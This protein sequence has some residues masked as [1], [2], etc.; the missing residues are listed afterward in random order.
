[1]A[2][3]QLLSHERIKNILQHAII[4]NRMPGAYCFSGEEGIGKDALAI[5]FARTVNCSNPVIND[6]L[7]DSCGECKSCRLFNELQ[8]PNLMFITALPSGT[9][10]ESRSDSPLDKLTAAQLALIKEQLGIKAEN[11]Y[12]QINIP[13]ANLIK[14]SSI[15][16]IKRKLTLSASHFGRRVVIISKADTMT[17]EAANAFLKTLEEPHENITIILTTSKPET[18]LPTIVSRCQQVQCE[19]LS[20]AEIARFLIDKYNVEAEKAETAAHFARGSLSRAADMLDDGVQI[21]RDMVVDMLRAAMKKN[22]F[23]IGLLVYIDEIVKDK[24]KNRVEM[25]LTMLMLWFRDAYAYQNTDN[26]DAIVFKDQA[27][28]IIKFTNYFKTDIC[29]AID[30]VEESIQMIKRNVQ[31]Q[32]I[33]ISLFIKLRSIFLKN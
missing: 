25:A 21:L 26:R 31:L 22:T 11:P 14:I 4:E 9:A 18:L 19:P 32:L 5:E 30:A 1:M 29:Q 13:K 15:R 8:H 23:R 16:E 10:A 7:I 3:N 6:R 12:H 33:F 2:W 17:P 24:D 28:A 27:E 20:A